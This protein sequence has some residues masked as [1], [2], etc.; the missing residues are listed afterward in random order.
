MYEP[1]A[2]KNKETQEQG[3]R[4]ATYASGLASWRARD[5]AKAAELFESAAGDDPPSRYF[6]KRARTLAANPPPA[7][8]TPVNV[9][10]GK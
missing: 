9:L 2:E 4:A 1:F 6:A 5:F 10:E 7:D 8:W 3:M